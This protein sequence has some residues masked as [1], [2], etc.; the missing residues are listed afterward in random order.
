MTGEYS[1][2]IKNR[3]VDFRFTVR[4][5]ITIVRGDSATGKT[6]LYDM[7]VALTQNGPESGVQLSCDKPC[8]ALIHADMQ[9]QITQL[10]N[11]RDSIVFVDEGDR[12]VVRKEFAETIRK[13]DNYYV[14]FIRDNLRDLPYSVEEI[15]EIRK[16]GKYHRFVNY[17]S[18]SDGYVYGRQGRKFQFDTIL[19]EDSKSGYQFFDSFC[20]DTDWRCESA[21]SKTQIYKWIKDHPA[22]RVFIVADGAAFGPEMNRVMELVE[23]NGNKAVICLPESFEWMILK[24]GVVKSDDLNEVMAAT[25]KYIDSK[26]YF[27]WEQFFTK[28]LIR[29]TKDSPYGKYSKSRLAKYYMLEKN[30]GD[31]AA[32]IMLGK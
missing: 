16:S 12:L 1:I 11:I 25:G 27:S 20:K 30:S 28:Y 21:Q 3:D 10:K 13:T 15:Y 8:V 2:R 18:K 23:R 7:V 6:T 17:Y 32:V 22:E 31:I 9:T 26:E 5:N 14:L 19:T 24:S 29:I 4:R